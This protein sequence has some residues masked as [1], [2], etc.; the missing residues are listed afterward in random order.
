MSKAHTSISLQHVCVLVYFL[1]Y[2]P[3]LITFK[4]RF[5][6]NK[7]THIEPPKIRPHEVSRSNLII[8]LSHKPQ[9]E[10]YVVRCGSNNGHHKCTCC[11]PTCSWSSYVPNC[12]LFYFIFVDC[13]IWHRSEICSI[14]VGWV[15]SEMKSTCEVF[16][17]CTK[18][19]TW[20]N[21]HAFG[22][23]C[24]LPMTYMHHLFFK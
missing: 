19:E 9:F 21:F 18:Y 5:P 3:C 10:W 20:E 22:G 23:G 15:P 11:T 16:P 2:K 8:Y 14:I 17:H 13:L 6:I 7:S 1:D 12:I 24:I 4:Y